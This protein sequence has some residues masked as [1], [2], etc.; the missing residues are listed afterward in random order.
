MLEPYLWEWGSLILRWIHVITAI[1]WIG[2]SFYFIH[3]DLSLKKTPSL[4][5]GVGGEAWQVHGGGFY[6]MQKYTV[7]PPE[8]PHDL[9]WFKWESYSTWIS[10]FFLLGWIYYA[11][12]DL[13]LVDPVVRALSPSAAAG[14]G[15]GS[16]IFGWLIYD[17][18]CR[19]PLG[20]NDAA[21][22]AVGF[23]FLVAAA[24]GFTL[25][26]GGRGAFIHTGALIA[27]MMTANVA[28]VI[29]P[30]QRKIVADLLAHR[31][32]DP[33]LGTAAKQRST[34]N[35][36]LT[37][38]VVFLMLA[39][40][41][42]LAFA[43]RWNWLIVALV[44]VAGAVIRHFYNSR[45]A[46]HPSPWWTW[47]V[48][49][50]TVALAVWLSMI[51]APGAGTVARPPAE[52]PA[53]ARAVEVMQTRCAMCHAREPVW[54]GIAVAPKGV[55]LETAADV[56]RQAEAIAVQAVLS[57]AMP[58]NNITEMTSGE[59]RTVA[60]WLAERQAASR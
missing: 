31:A 41:Y 15:I 13:Y 49:G 23:A 58:P 9:T 50:A 51:G 53:F 42:P 37:L 43:S 12:P 27:T 8:L 34:H 39:N 2:S 44:I 22:A 59:R 7:A 16:L 26:F 40:H 1:A 35:N 11:Q 18:L 14:I 56:A 28:R 4:A 54:A 17:G 24:Y 5:E 57:Q 48:A 55:L 19:S 6:R 32:P 45:H 52:T 60:A 25:V 21:L 33:A 29:I 10:G 46:G 20:R 3:L 38:P 36:Y 30:N 47:G